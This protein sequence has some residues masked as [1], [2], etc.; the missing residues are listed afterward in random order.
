MI[1]GV[2]WGEVSRTPLNQGGPILYK[3]NAEGS[4]M[5]GKDA[6]AKELRQQIDQANTAEELDRARREYVR[7]LQQDEWRVTKRALDDGRPLLREMGAAFATECAIIDW[8][9]DQL[10]ATHP[11][12]AIGMG[13]PPGVHG[14]A[15]TL[16]DAGLKDL[17]IKLKIEDDQVF[18]L[19]FHR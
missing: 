10:R 6:R 16:K 8:I 18:V 1:S 4:S 3:G 2:L 5:A 14:I 19:S 17:Y 7:L 12:R 11:L 15:H 9:L 13:E